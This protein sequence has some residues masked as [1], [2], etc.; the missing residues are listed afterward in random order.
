MALQGDKRSWYCTTAI[1]H[2]SYDNK[3]GVHKQ[4][5]EL[6][7]WPCHMTLSV[8]SYLLVNES[9]KGPLLACEMMVCMRGS[10]R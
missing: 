3:G 4:T 8:P 1:A 10:G 6:C 9:S 7:L 2:I 5:Y